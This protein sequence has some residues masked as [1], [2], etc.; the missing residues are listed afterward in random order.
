MIF[1]FLLQDGTK[2]GKI[3]HEKMGWTFMIKDKKIGNYNE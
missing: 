3:I 2:K 1:L